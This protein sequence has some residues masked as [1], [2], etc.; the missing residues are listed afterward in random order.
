M[1]SGSAGSVRAGKAYYELS[2]DRGPL[3][4]GLKG[5]EALVKGSVAAAGSKI[6]EISASLGKV[7]VN[8]LTALAAAAVP[9]TALHLFTGLGAELVDT[10]RITG[11]A[12][13]S[14]ARLDYVAKQ[15]GQSLPSVASAIVAIRD[16][17]T[18]AARGSEEAQIAFARLGINF[19]QL[20]R[21]APDERL[22]VLAQRLTA[23]Q[24]P[25]LRAAF[26]A[27]VLGSADLLPMLE[28]MQELEARAKRL[29]LT[30]STQD[31]Q[32]AQRFSQA[33][34]DLHAN[35]L[36]TATVV[37]AK[38]APVLTDLINKWI[39]AS[40]HTRQWI[41]ANLDAFGSAEALWAGIK[42]LWA[43]GAAFV[44][45]KW[46]TTV[47][48]L[49]E[50]W[51]NASAAMQKGWTVFAHVFSGT[52]Q[53][54]HNAILGTI[55]AIGAMVKVLEEAL[56]AVADLAAAIGPGVG[57]AIKVLADKLRDLGL[58]E[59][60]KKLQAGVVEILDLD[61]P[62]LK[63]K[64]AAI[65]ADRQKRLK[66]VQANAPQGNAAADAANIARLQ[67]EFDEKVAEAKRRAA[68][69]AAAKPDR[70]VGDFAPGGPGRLGVGAAMFHVRGIGAQDVRTK[71]GFASL[72]ETM[73]Q[74]QNPMYR[75][76]QQSYQL[77]QRAWIDLHNIRVKTDK[78]GIVGL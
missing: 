49:Q 67:K 8:P 30:M 61:N 52:L 23:I 38:I 11:V 9:A 34:A 6:K 75:L 12:A 26:A 78:I 51:I 32:A 46:N 59:I 42:L 77:Q 62:E 44:A 17:L 48:G 27:D 25:F 54:M 16:K 74:T 3:E 2:A 76:A 57:L 36:A 33:L 71:E 47:V 58:K 35:M 4:K 31:A 28:R 53:F 40:A 24:N 65:E 72:L 69:A 41:R 5:A 60:A 63:K 22:R 37:G 7:L 13:D 10:S 15:T 20:S 45:E 29:G 18:E 70:E 39:A 14:L 21:L 56:R 50:K 1:P 68:A 43:Q 73:K 64:L 19:M 55:E 66:D